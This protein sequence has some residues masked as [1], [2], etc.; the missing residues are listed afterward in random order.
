MTNRKNQG[1]NLHKL[2]YHATLENAHFV[3]DQNTY[4]RVKP[5]KYTRHQ[6]RLTSVTKIDNLNLSRNRPTRSNRFRR[7][8]RNTLSYFSF[9]IHFPSWRT[10]IWRVFARPWASSCF[11]TSSM[12][13][14]T[15]SICGRA[16]DLQMG[17][18]H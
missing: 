1:Y 13:P 18:F 7:G 11:L 6:N 12:K 8:T 15:K 2:H 5:E 3:H 17:H 14:S 16:S 4:M 9:S 10:M